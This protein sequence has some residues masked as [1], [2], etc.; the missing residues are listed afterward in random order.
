MKTMTCL[1]L[2]PLLAAT[3]PVAHAQVEKPNIVYFL[4]DDLGY[5]DCGFNGGKDIQTPQI[6]RLAREGAVL[7]SFYVQ[8]VC[9]PTRSALLTGRYVTHT[10]VYTIV[11][12][13]ASWGLPLGERLLPEALK[14]EGY[15]TA[16]CGKWHLGEFQPAYTPTNRGFDHQ[17]GH[18]FGAIDYF[19]HIRDGKPDWYRDDKPLKEEGYS[20]ELLA[21]EAVR[22]IEAQP[23]DKPL[24]LYLPFNGIH[25]PHQVPERYLTPYQNLPKPR[26][27]IAGM[28]SA[29]DQAIGQVVAA[30]EAKGLRKNT[31]I[32]FS[33]DNGGPGPGRVTM[34]T[35]LRAGKGTIY[36]GGV[37]AAAFATWPGKIPAGQTIDEPLHAVDWFPTLL[38]LAGATREQKLPVDGRDLWPVLTKRAKSPHDVLLLH[39]TRPGVAAVRKGDWKL[40]VN[41]SERDAEEVGEGEKLGGRVEL[42][43]LKDDLSERTNVAASQPEKVKELRAELAALLRDAVPAG[44]AKPATVPA[45]PNAAKGRATL[46]D[47]KDTNKDGKLSLEEFLVGPNNQANP[48]AA[49]MRF[50][51]FD[52][53]K[54]GFL[55]REEFVSQGKKTQAV[56]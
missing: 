37:R 42:Y 12:P 10:G 48:Q 38:T 35:P 9:S 4:V 20:T 8:P 3:V 15:T 17:Y 5:A 11:T 19:T 25:A 13:G 2:L 24:F 29:V 52:T 49:R 45:A 54:D 33:S 27:T 44:G 56:R 40:L 46:F 26:Q 6:D 32:V 50:T 16:I 18:F 7:K 14:E 43:N 1:A 23:K 39:G 53:N 21:K 36:E 30:L 28:L 31:L 55:S 22:L 41:A 51:S 34:N 47:Q